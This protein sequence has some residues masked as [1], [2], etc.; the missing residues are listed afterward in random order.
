MNRLK[1]LF[2]RRRLY[3]DLD[4]EITSHL[5]ERIEELVASGMPLKEATAAAHRQFGNVGLV[6][7]TAREAWGWRWLEDLFGDLWFGLRIQ[8]KNLGLTLVAVLIAGLG[9]AANVTVFSVVNALF[10]R[11]VPAK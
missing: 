9:I 7:E 11:S 4:E 1:H 8:R 3:D 6:K 2:L 10:L 5:E